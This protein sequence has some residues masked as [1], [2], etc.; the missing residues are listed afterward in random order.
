MSHT[1]R[2]QEKLLARVR[3]LKG[4][5]EAVERALEARQACGDI[6]NLVASVRGAVNGLTIELIEDHIRGHVAGHESQGEREEGAAEL[7]E[8]VRRYLK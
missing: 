7:I 4:Q 3:R 1:I 5:M 6:L 2:D 8:I